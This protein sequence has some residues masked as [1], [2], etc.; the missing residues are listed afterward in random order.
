M[1]TLIVS[2]LSRLGRSVGQIIS[3]V[4]T[5]IKQEVR[6]IAIKNPAMRSFFLTAP[7]S[8]AVAQVMMSIC[9]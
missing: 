4:D 1:D 7:A 3:I 5:L 6:F 9:V 8:A 2:E